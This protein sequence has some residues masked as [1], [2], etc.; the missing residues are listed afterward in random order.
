MALTATEY[1]EKQLPIKASRYNVANMNVTH[2]CLV[3]A[4]PGLENRSLQ[5][6]ATVDLAKQWI[7]ITISSTSTKNR[8]QQTQ[9]ATCTVQCCD[10]DR[11]WSFVARIQHL[12]KSRISTLEHHVPS[13]HKIF[14]GLVY[15][16]LSTLVDMDEKYRGMDEV[17][18]NSEQ[19]EAMAQVSLKEHSDCGSFHIDPYWIDSLIHISAFILNGN[20]LS[21]SDQY[22]YISS[23][24]DSMQ[25]CKPLVAGTDYRVYVEMNPVLPNDFGGDVWVFKGN[26]VIGHV[27]NIKFRQI[28]RSVLKTIIHGSGTI[29]TNLPPSR[30]LI[31]PRALRKMSK[32]VVPVS[33]QDT[34][35]EENST[36]NSVMAILA[37]EIGIPRSDIKDHDKLADI[38]IDS[39]MALTIAAKIKQKLTVEI[40]GTLLLE[41]ET[42]GD[43]L[44]LVSE[45]APMFTSDDDSSS[46]DS[47]YFSQVK[48]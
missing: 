22:L 1:I 44:Q 2:P 10:D 14:R 25:F 9:H 24:W 42:I 6:I 40:P 23:G 33:I 28:Q 8:I 41:K 32:S 19:L 11:Q 35:P 18:L 20:E 21:D 27:G 7:N 48:W 17:F 12:V 29:V 45:M 31:S 38:G 5:L 13:V 36:V 43:A 47:G 37:E 15:R 46:G 26:V 3:E 34:V 4:D 16:L 39:L 30:S